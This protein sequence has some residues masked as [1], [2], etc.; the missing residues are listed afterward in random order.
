MK[1]EAERLLFEHDL[2]TPLTNLRGAHYLLKMYLKSPSP[3]VEEALAILESNIRT[4]E[5]MA[6]WYWRI[7]ELQGALQETEPWP[8][9]DAAASL[10]R[11]AEAE[12]TGI[13]PPEGEP[14]G[15]TVVP[16]LPLETGLLGAALTLAAAAG[17]PPRWTFEEAEGEATAVY[18]LQG[19]S[20]L[21]DAGRL[22]RKV[23]WPG[24]PPLKAWLDPGLPYLA[25]VLEPFGGGL[26]LVHGQGLWRL[27]ARIPLAP[28]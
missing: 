25:A 24:G 3:E 10:R 27:L 26:E 1:P 15:L 14:R 13:A 2:A 7:R 16:R 22:L 20:D 21:L 6:G 23:Y 4:V 19:D 5:R 17:R 28:P 9:A 18:S 12:R 11:T 8:L